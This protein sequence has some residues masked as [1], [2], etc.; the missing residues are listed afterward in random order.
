MQFLTH[1]TSSG[2]S[3]SRPCGRQGFDTRQQKVCC[4]D[5]EDE[6]TPARSTFSILDSLPL[7]LSSSRPGATQHLQSMGRVVIGVRS[8]A[9]ANTAVSSIIGKIFANR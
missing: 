5:K 2:F 7:P 8:F 9:E 3:L 6:A 4:G 1:T